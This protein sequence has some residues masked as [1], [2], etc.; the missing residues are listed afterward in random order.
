MNDHKGVVEVEYDDESISFKQRNSF[1][2]RNAATIRLLEKAW[3]SYVK[4]RTPP[5]PRRAMSIYTDDGFGAHCDYS[6]AVGRAEDVSRCMPSFI[7]DSWPECGIDSYERV[8]AEMVS[9]GDLPAADDRAFWIGNISCPL[10]GYDN[11]RMGLSVASRHPDILD[12]RSVE[13]HPDPRESKSTAGYV[14]LPDHCRYRVLIDFGGMGFSARIPLLLASGRPVVLVGH[15]QEAWFYWDGSLKP[16]VHYVP[17]GSADGSDV[18][19]E[20]IYEAI[21]WTFDNG[22][23]C[24]EIGARGREYAE[25]HLTHAAAL[26]RIGILLLGH[27]SANS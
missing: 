1:Q 18:S 4:G 6:F 10:K 8:F 19:E 25:H 11:R 21:I 7:F 13:W 9:A 27:S 12:F 2:S 15:P 23:L 16:W 20:K 17:C 3:G 14:S 5:A 26:E 22:R 24:A